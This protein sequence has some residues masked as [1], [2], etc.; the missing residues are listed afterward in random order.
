MTLMD[1][2]QLRLQNQR[3][4]GSDFKTPADVVRH[5][6]AMQAQDYASAKWAIG[7]RLPGSTE[8]DIE[9]AVRDRKILRTW[10]QRGTIHFVV[11]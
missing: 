2:A 11:P 1:I 9:Q 6:G 10:P 5:M 8:A 3:I 4:V 7:L